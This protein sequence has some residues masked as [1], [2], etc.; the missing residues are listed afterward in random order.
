MNGLGSD[1]RKKCFRFF[2]H[3]T[4]ECSVALKKSIKKSLRREIL[5]DFSDISDLSLWLISC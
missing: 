5:S 3:R 1:L 4:Y 2:N